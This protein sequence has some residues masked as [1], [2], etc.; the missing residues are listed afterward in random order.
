MSIYP[1]AEQFQTLL[2]GPPDRPVVMLNLLRFKPSAD[3]PDTGVSGTEAY[4]RYGREMRK[5]VE[6]HGGR[7]LWSGRVDSMV[8]ADADPDYHA[9]ALVEYPSRAKF[10][11]I[12]QSAEVAGIGVH[13]TAGLESQWLIAMTQGEI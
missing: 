7:I 13:R 5:I 4:S 9:V 6:S 2:A 12:A 3:A 10:V 11:E 8:I 1:S